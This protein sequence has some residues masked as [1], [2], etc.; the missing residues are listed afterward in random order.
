MCALERV[1]LRASEEVKRQTMVGG[2]DRK[3]LM[4]KQEHL[5]RQGKGLPWIR[6]GRV[7]AS[8]QSKSLGASAFLAIKGSAGQSCGA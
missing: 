7:R 5:H 8:A 3:L 1:S 6:A 2:R 4:H